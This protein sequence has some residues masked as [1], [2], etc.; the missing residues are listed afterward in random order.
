MSKDPILQ[1]N[2]YMQIHLYHAHIPLF[3]LFAETIKSLSKY[4]RRPKNIT[5]C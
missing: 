1:T 5:D 2:L 4:H 3:M